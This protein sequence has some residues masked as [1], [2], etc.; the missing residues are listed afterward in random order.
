MFRRTL[1]AAALIAATS[2]SAQAGTADDIAL[3]VDVDLTAYLVNMTAANIS[4]DG[5]Q[6][7][8][9]N[10][11]LDVDGWYSISDRVEQGRTQELMAELGAGALGFGE[12]SPTSAQ[13]SE[14]NISGV[15]VLKAGAKFSI[16]KPFSSCPDTGGFAF[17]FKVGGIAHHDGNSSG[18]GV[19]CPEPSTWLLAV[20][21][22]IGMATLRRRSR[23]RVR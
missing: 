2:V 13:I 10:N 17:F 1:W 4:F 6:I 20:L 19:A 9:E 3:W 14:A 21:G 7:V 8:S 15:G 23:A 5:Y 11:D 16:G 18:A 12:M 22:V